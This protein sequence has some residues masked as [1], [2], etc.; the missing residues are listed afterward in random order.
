MSPRPLAALFTELRREYRAI[1]LTT[2]VVT[3][4]L[5]AL[6]TLV[7]LPAF[8][9]GRAVVL[10]EAPAPGFWAAMTGLVLLRAL[11]TWSEMDLSH[12]VAYRVLA[13]LRIALF[14]RYAVALPSRRRENTGDAAATAL[15]DTEKLEFFYAHTVAQLFAA[16]VV[17]LTGLTLLTVAYPPLA[18]VALACLAGVAGTAVLGRRRLH[19]LGRLA[20]AQTGALSAHV[21][22]VLGGLREVLGYGLAP[23]VRADVAAR[24]ADAARTAGRIET[25]QRLLG[26]LRETGVTVAVVAVLTVAAFGGVPPEHLAGL[27]TM[28]LATIAAAADAATTLTQLRPVE[29]SASRVRDELTRPAVVV[30]A[31]RPRPL[32]DGPLG[33]AFREVTFGYGEAAVLDR[34][35]LDVAP[36]ERVGVR[37][38]SGA[39]KS[40]LVA[41]AGRLWDPDSGVVALTAGGGSALGPGG[42]AGGGAGGRTGG[43]A[44]GRTSGGSGEVSLTELADTE[45]RRAVGVVEQDGRLFSGSVSEN[46]L[47]G[48]DANEAELVRVLGALGLGDDVGPGDHVGEGGLRLSGGQ[49]SRLRLARAVLRRPRVLVVDEPTAD[50]DAGSADRVHRLLASLTCTLLVVS[51]QEATLAGMDRVID[52]NRTLTPAR[53]R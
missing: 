11:L 51:H 21:V 36:G 31:A 39:G 42:G 3:A 7:V 15:T 26:A 4:S 50:L 37:G 27:V 18:L 52:L 17:C 33:L 1:A 38:P 46:L 43:G 45:L 48:T 40:T 22:D 16:A 14:D 6:G 25:T 10:G 28:A 35:S 5:L 47:R 53:T 2:A 29:A 19:G 34:F 30:P 12:A 8:A 41:L 9:L 20:T 24:G 32:P 13:R 49:Q 44:G 23:R